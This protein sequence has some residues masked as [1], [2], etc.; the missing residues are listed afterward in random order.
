MLRGCTSYLNRIFVPV[1]TLAVTA[2][3][4]ITCCVDYRHA[5]AEHPAAHQK[6]AVAAELQLSPDLAKL[7]KAEMSALEE[8]MKTL[9]PA[10]ISGDWNAVAATGEQL[11]DSYI[12]QQELTAELA[13]E[14]HRALPP[15]FLE[16]DQ[17]FHHSA[18]KLV[19]AAKTGNP[20]VVAFYFYKLTDTCMACHSKYAPHRFPGLAGTDSQEEHRH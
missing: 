9:I 8:G 13:A 10:I 18:D 15:A 17:S 20:E 14:L 12:L 6:T 19:H 4:A 16:L 1:N 3:L 11:R 5:Y 2:L 7:F